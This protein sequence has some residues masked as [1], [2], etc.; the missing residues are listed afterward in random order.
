MPLGQSGQ[1][2]ADIETGLFQT[3]VRRLKSRQPNAR[4][5][6][7]AAR[8]WQNESA[9]ADFVLLLLR[10]QPPDLCCAFRSMDFGIALDIKT[11][12]PDTTPGSPPA[13][14]PPA[15]PPT[16]WPAPRAAPAAANLP[17]PA[18]RPPAPGT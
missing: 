3:R 18:S 13:S 11:A 5:R 12:H 17:G 7:P 10:F 14:A 8:F 4:S 16:I 1:E 9:K 2:A 6:P 15:L